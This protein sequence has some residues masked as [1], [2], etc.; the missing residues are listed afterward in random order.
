MSSAATSCLSVGPLGLPQGMM[1]L[2]WSTDIPCKNNLLSFML[3]LKI[4]Q[5]INWLAGHP[6]ARLIDLALVP[7]SSR[8]FPVWWALGKVPSDPTANRPQIWSQYPSSNPVSPPKPTWSL[9]VKGR[10]AHLATCL[11]V[12]YHA[13]QTMG[14]QKVVSGIRARAELVFN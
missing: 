3:P 14:T 8:I 7:A 10:R 13:L 4:A 11:A 5:K 2:N 6:W 1:M 9:R 12:F